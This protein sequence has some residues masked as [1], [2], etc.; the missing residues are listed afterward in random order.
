MNEK[1][2]LLNANKFI[3]SNLCT[4]SW[5]IY[6]AIRTQY[7]AEEKFASWRTLFQV[8]VE[9]IN[10]D[11][12]LTYAQELLAMPYLQQVTNLIFES[13]KLYSKNAIPPSSIQTEHTSTLN[14]G[15]VFGSLFKNLAHD[16]RKRGGLAKN[17]KVK[18][19]FTSSSKQTVLV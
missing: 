1:D 16:K 18:K 3:I 4:H 12:K 15:S 11:Q 9:L 17:R 8:S 5:T 2:D 14:R 19:L 13:C 6:R 10:N 7:V